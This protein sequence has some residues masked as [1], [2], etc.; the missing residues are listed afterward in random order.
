MPLADPFHYLDAGITRE[1]AS[2]CGWRVIRSREMAGGDGGGGRPTK[3]RYS[4][5]SI[6]DFFQRKRLHG[7]RVVIDEEDEV[8][9]ED[10]EDAQ[11]STESADA[12]EGVEAISSEDEAEADAASVTIVESG[13]VRLQATRQHRDD[14][15]CV[16]SL[17]YRRELGECG[18][19]APHKHRNPRRRLPQLITR[20]ALGTFQ[21]SPVKLA[22]SA[23]WE[24][25][26]ERL[27]N[28]EFYA[29]CIE[30]D[31]AGVLLAAGSSNG[32]IAIYDFDEY[33][34]RSI[35]AGHVSYV[36]LIVIHVIH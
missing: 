12:D 1:T 32:I 28:E 27:R 31:S 7:A 14:R 9:A 8:D 34:H 3:K 29:S 15:S 36:L 24:H 23:D 4:A 25:R 22:L 30:F 10:A 33:A 26:A 19:R 35:N 6:M 5:T 16:T 18:G 11:R 20:W 17:L 2:K 13:G 21:C